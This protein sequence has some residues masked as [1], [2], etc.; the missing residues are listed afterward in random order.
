[1]ELKITPSGQTIVK[2]TALGPVANTDSKLL[3]YGLFQKGR[4]LAQDADRLSAA[5]HKEI[6]PE[7]FTQ[8]NES[9]LAHY[10]VEGRRIQVSKPNENGDVEQRHY[11]LKEA[12]DQTLMLRGSR[13]FESREDYKKFLERLFDELNSGRRERVQE[14]LKRLRRLPER[15][16]ESHKRV[17]VGVKRSSSTIRVDG[18]TYSVDSRLIGEDCG[19]SCPRRRASGVV[20]L[21]F[22]TLI[23]N[24]PR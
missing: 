7:V 13:D 15:R 5:V 1:M 16:L 12:V 4:V 22:I 3:I 24:P 20:R 9:L 17:S 19:S 23:R 8:R 6:H 18:N 21:L 11:R 14:E 2:P 10:G